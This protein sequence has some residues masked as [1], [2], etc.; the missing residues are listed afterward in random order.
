MTPNLKTKPP[1]P[2]LL[3]HGAHSGQQHDET[4]TAENWERIGK[5]K[6]KPLPNHFL[7]LSQPLKKWSGTQV[8]SPR[9]RIRFGKHFQKAPKQK[10]TNHHQQQSTCGYRAWQQEGQESTHRNVLKI[11]V[12]K[13]VLSFSASVSS[14]FYPVTPQKWGHLGCI[15]RSSSDPDVAGS[16][17]SQQQ[18]FSSPIFSFPFCK[19]PTLSSHP[20]AN[21]FWFVSLEPQIKEATSSCYFDSCL[22]EKLFLLTVQQHTG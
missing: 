8:L 11:Q 13:V 18:A 16:K 12:E 3:V 2:P 19:N 15:A 4:G 21:W 10:Q 9:K 14:L 22:S 5:R 17:C 6:R 20:K 1:Q 7:L